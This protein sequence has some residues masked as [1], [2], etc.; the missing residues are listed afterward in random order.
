[1]VLLSLLE[2]TAQGSIFVLKQTYHLGSWMIWGRQ[3]TKEEILEEKL[4]KQIEREEKLLDRLEKL[5][6]DAEE[7][8][9]EEIK[10]ELLHGDDSVAVNGRRKSF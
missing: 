2:L 8:R 4:E 3:K 1:M 5:E 10:Y 7:Q 6:H 9:R